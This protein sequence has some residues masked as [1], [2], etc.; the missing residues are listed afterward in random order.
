MSLRR[1][2][3]PRRP[4]ALA[5]APIQHGQRG[6]AQERMENDSFAPQ[7][8]LGECFAM[9]PAEVTPC[10]TPGGGSGPSAAPR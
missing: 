3:L 1:P 8:V 9:P 6:Q 4:D 10:P 5:L 7:N 2:G